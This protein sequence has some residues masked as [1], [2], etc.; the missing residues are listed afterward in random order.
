MN[1]TMPKKEVYSLR[2]LL[3]D[4]LNSLDDNG[5]EAD[6][7]AWRE[8][9]SKLVIIQTLISWAALYKAEEYKDDKKLLNALEVK[10]RGDELLSCYMFYVSTNPQFEYTWSYMRNQSGNYTRFLVKAVHFLN[11]VVDDINEFAGRAKRG[12]DIRIVFNN[13]IEVTLIDEMPFVKSCILWKNFHYIESIDT[14]YN[15]IIKAE[16][17]ILK[18]ISRKDCSDILE[19]VNSSLDLIRNN[20]GDSE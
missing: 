8:H 4:I 6:V 17:V 16:D 9:Q 13:L 19:F 12:I 18:I 3:D 2:M 11:N 14:D 10:V 20:K 15:I 7:L 5:I 1:K